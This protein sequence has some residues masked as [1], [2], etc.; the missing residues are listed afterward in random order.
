MSFMESSSETN[1][2]VGDVA[3]S[4]SE[5]DALGD[6]VI[7]GTGLHDCL[8]RGGHD[9]AAVRA[10]GFTR[11]L[12]SGFT[13]SSGLTLRLLARGP[14]TLCLRGAFGFFGTAALG[15]ES[16]GMGSFSSFPFFLCLALGLGLRALLSSR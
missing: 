14:I 16:F 2:D 12:R 6:G 10:V 9:I 8:F 4:D 13:I 3:C 7:D 15:G 11:G 1:A 5:D